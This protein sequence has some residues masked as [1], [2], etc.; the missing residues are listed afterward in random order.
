[1][2]AAARLRALFEPLRLYSFASGTL[3]AAEL[4]AA[5]A[6]IDGFLAQ[7][8]LLEREASPLTAEGEGLALWEE[9]LG[10]TPPQSVDARRRAVLV[11]LAS[12][13]STS[14]AALADTLAI[15]GLDVAIAEDADDR[16]V[17]VVSF[18]GVAGIPEGFAAMRAVIEEL[19]P[20]H[21]EPRYDFRYI[22]WTLFERHFPT[23]QALESSGLDWHGIEHIIE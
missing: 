23:W 18:P 16:E 8:L 17:I 1:M 6:A 10:H 2:S 21:L 20:C 5:G 7:L 19:L 12:D 14:L 4:D 9:L 13:G 15:C 3:S 11:Q 22:S